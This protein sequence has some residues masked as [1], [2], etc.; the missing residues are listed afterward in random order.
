MN[1]KKEVLT[2]NAIEHWARSS[3][4]LSPITG[5]VIGR[6]GVGQVVPGELDHGI[7]HGHIID[8]P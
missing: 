8:S 1:F 2:L 3:S 4:H 7:G 5:E 6:T